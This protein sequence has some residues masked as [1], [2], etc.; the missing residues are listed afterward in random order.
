MPPETGCI[1]SRGG[2]N[3][4]SLA[5]TRSH[6]TTPPKAHST[7]NPAIAPPI[8]ADSLLGSLSFVVSIV[9]F[10][11]CVSGLVGTG[12]VIDAVD[13]VDGAGVVDDNGEVADGW[14]EEDE[15]LEDANWLAVGGVLLGVE[16]VV[17]GVDLGKA[18]R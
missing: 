5:R 17:A 11:A 9:E 16:V 12:G 8:I 14:L 1:C 3:R 13:P 10:P 18:S 15:E 7:T 4:A 2:C 6:V